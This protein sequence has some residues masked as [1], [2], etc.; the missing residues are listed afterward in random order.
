MCATHNDAAASVFMHFNGSRHR[1]AIGRLREAGRV[2]ETAPL[3]PR[4]RAAMAEIRRA[5]DDDAFFA[6]LLR[7]AEED[8]GVQNGAGDQGQ[9]AD[10]GD[11]G[12][13]QEDEKDDEDGAVGGA[14]EDEDIDR[15]G[16]EEENNTHGD[17]VE[18]GAVKNNSS[19]TGGARGRRDASAPIAWPSAMVASRNTV[20]AD[21]PAHLENRY[22]GSDGRGAATPQR[23]STKA[24]EAGGSARGG[25]EFGDGVVRKGGADAM[26]GVP[27][28]SAAREGRAL[29]VGPRRS[30]FR[31]A[32][33]RGSSARMY[34]S[35]C[36][37]AVLL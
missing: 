2:S 18:T 37:G 28:T 10:Q 31:P 21:G 23:Y 29:L 16:A 26:P 34:D 32:L 7:N 14:Q 4:L 17:A 22:R 19:R 27:A 33:A 20:R 36:V 30:S 8:A 3:V 6:V 9:L 15:D 35:E 1:R 24:R 13:D 25:V 5:G 11:V 12:G